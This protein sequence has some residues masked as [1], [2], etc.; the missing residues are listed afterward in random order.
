MDI[1]KHSY[2]SVNE[3]LSD[4][5][6]L[7]GDRGMEILSKGFY[8]SQIQ[9]A[10]EGLSFDTFFDVRRES[11]PFPVNDLQL[12]MPLGAFNLK[13]IYLFHGTQCDITRSQKVW[14]KRDYYTEGTGYFAN[15]KGDNW[16]DPFY[17]SNSY[18]TRPAADVVNSVDLVRPYSSVNNHYFYNIQNGIIM[19]SSACR[20]FEKVHI[21][22][23][24]TGCDI[25]DE[26]I[27]PM[28]LREAVKDYVCEVALRARM[29]MDP[30]V[31]AIW[32]IYDRN[33]NR[34]EKYGI[35]VG[36]WQRAEYRVKKMN[37]NDLSCLKEYL[38]RMAY[39]STG[40]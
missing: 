27:V 6:E 24:G 40:M 38:G 39:G 17:P 21:V 25:G 13:E 2:V 23:N 34:D 5:L 22:Y 32:A 31:Q 35:G 37:Y 16:G 7:V 36:S 19:F 33:L 15:N 29:I 20:G 26:P 9:Q 3:I 12:E 28:F 8:T 11:F 30:K 4:V 10:L 1:S 14:W 18:R